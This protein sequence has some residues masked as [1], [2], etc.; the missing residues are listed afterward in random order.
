MN[1][2]I[3]W[4]KILTALVFLSVNLHSQDLPHSVGLAPVQDFAISPVATG[5]DAS[6]GNRYFAQ[7]S[8]SPTFQFGKAFTESCTITNVGAPFTITFPGGL[9]FRNGIVYTWNQS[10]PYQLWSIDTTTGVHTLV[11]NMSGVPYTN[12]TGM[13]WDGSYVYGL[14]TSLTQSQIFTINMTTGA[15][16]PIGIYSTMCDGGI[17][18]LGLKS[19]QNSLFVLDIVTDSLFKVNKTTG[20]F[21]RIGPLGVDINF[22]QDGSV[23]L[24]DNTFY[25]MAY[26]TASEL[27]KVDTVSGNLGPVLCTYTAQGTGMTLKDPPIPPPPVGA[28]ST[29]C[30]VSINVPINDNS[31][32]L[33]SVNVNEGNN[34][35][36]LDVNVRI[37]S[38]LHTWDSDLSFYLR[39]GPLGVKIINRAG[40]SGDNFIGTILND[41]AINPISSGVAPFTDSYK[42]S[43]PLTIFNSQPTDG[44]WKLLISDTAVGNTGVLK[45]WCVLI[46]YQPFFGGIQTIEIPNY[47]FLNQNYPN[48]FN[49]VTNIKFGIPESGNVRLVVYDILGREVATLMNER[50]N[51]GTYEVNFDASQFASGIYFYSLQ[52]ERVT[53]TKRM[54]LVK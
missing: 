24:F 49:P 27:R 41:S 46:T 16:T 8:S 11:F 15:C 36:I 19:A 39:K 17:T 13:C 51:P 6:I 32:L 4:F 14:A 2:K 31:A 48:P 37:D 5:F 1:I 44:Y 38:V 42:P 10:S 26:S 53:E 35:I 29:A 9:M 45:R 50:K 54:L 7:I 20:V 25:A 22:G 52:T 34:C 12:F 40:D 3:S 43:N 21:S 23:D 30:R 47:Y 28:L 33:D 18:L